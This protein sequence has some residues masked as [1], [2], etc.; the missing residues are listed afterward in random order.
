[1][2]DTI[3]SNTI[4]INKFVNVSINLYYVEGGQWGE[5]SMSLDRSFWVQYLRHDLSNDIIIDFNKISTLECKENEGKNVEMSRVVNTDTKDLKKEDK[6]T[7]NNVIKPKFVNDTPGKIVINGSD[8]QINWEWKM[9]AKDS[10]NN[11]NYV[12][13]KIYLHLFDHCTDT[14]LTSLHSEK[15]VPNNGTYA[16][17][18]DIPFISQRSS[19]RDVYLV[20]SVSIDEIPSNIKIRGK[21]MASKSLKYN[22]NNN[23]ES[24]FHR[25]DTKNMG[26]SIS[27][28]KKGCGVDTLSKQVIVAVSNSF[29][30][31]RLTTISEFEFLYATFCRTFGLEMEVVTYNDLSKYGFHVSKNNLRIC[32]NIRKSIPSEVNYGGTYCPGQYTI[33]SKALAVKI[34][35]NCDINKSNDKS[36][37]DMES[38][39]FLK[40]QRKYIDIIENCTLNYSTYWWLSSPDRFLLKNGIILDT[41]IFLPLTIKIMT[42]LKIDLLILYMRNLSITKMLN[43][44]KRRFSIF[45]RYKTASNNDFYLQ[46]DD[47]GGGYKKT[48]NISSGLLVHSNYST[49]YRRRPTWRSGK[50]NAWR[51]ILNFVSLK[52]HKNARNGSL[53]DIDN[54]GKYR[55][56]ANINDKTE[57]GRNNDNNRFANKMSKEMKTINKSKR[58][59]SNALMSLKLAQLKKSPSKLFSTGGRALKKGYIALGR[60]DNNDDLDEYKSGDDNIESMSKSF[61][62]ESSGKFSREELK[63]DNNDASL[64]SM[65]ESSCKYTELTNLNGVGH[66]RRRISSSSAVDYKRMKTRN[67]DDCMFYGY[68]IGYGGILVPLYIAKIKQRQEIIREIWYKL[69]FSTFPVV[70]KA[71]IYVFQLTLLSIFPIT[72]IILTLLYNYLSTQTISRPHTY[73]SENYLSDIVFNPRWSFFMSI[74]FPVPYLILISLL[75]LLIINITFISS[76]TSYSAKASVINNNVNGNN[77]RMNRFYYYWIRILIFFEDI[78]MFITLFSTFLTLLAISMFFLWFLLGSLINSDNI[79]PYVVMLLALGFVIVSL[80]NNFT[81]SR[82]IVDKFIAEN[83]QSLISIAL[84]HWFEATNQNYNIMNN[85]VVN[86]T[87]NSNY[88]PSFSD[89]NDLRSK[90]SEKLQYEILNNRYAWSKNILDEHKYAHNL[91]NSTNKRYMI[92]DYMDVMELKHS[93]KMSRMY[94]VKSSSFSIL[95]DYCDMYCLKWEYMKISPINT[96]R[97]F[98]LC[99]NGDIVG[100]NETISIYYGMK[101]ATKKDVLLN[102]SKING[103]LSDLDIV[104][105]KDGIKYG[106]KYGYKLKD[107]TDKD[108]NW[109]KFALVKIPIFPTS[110]I[111]SEEAKI[112]LIFDFFDVDQDGYLNKKETLQWIINLNYN[113]KYFVNGDNTKYTDIVEY[114]N[115][116]FNL[117]VDDRYGFVIDDIYTIYSFN[118]KNVNIDYEKIIPVFNYSCYENMDI[119]NVNNSLVGERDRSGSEFGFGVEFDQKKEQEGDNNENCGIKN[120]N[121]NNKLIFVENYIDEEEYDDEFE[122]NIFKLSG[123]EYNW[124]SSSNNGLGNSVGNNLEE[125]NSFVS[126]LDQK[127]YLWTDL[128]SNDNNNIMYKRESRCNNKTTEIKVI[129]TDLN[130]LKL[131]SLNK[132]KVNYDIV[133]NGNKGKARGRK[134]YNKFQLL[135]EINVQKLKYIFTFA[136]R[137][138]KTPDIETALKDIHSLAYKVF[139]A[140]IALLIPIFGVNNVLT[141][142]N[143]SLCLR[144]KSFSNWR[145][146]IDGDFKN[147]NKGNNNEKRA[148]ILSLG[149]KNSYQASS[150]L[151]SSFSSTSFVN[152]NG[153]GNTR[154]T[155]NDSN[156]LNMSMGSCNLNNVLTSGNKYQRKQSINRGGSF[157][158]MENNINSDSNGNVITNSNN[159]NSNIGYDDGLGE[160]EEDTV[161]FLQLMRILHN[162]IRQ[163]IWLLFNHIL[164]KLFNNNRVKN[165][166]NHFLDTIYPKLVRSKA[167]RIVNIFYGPS[168]NELSV[169]IHEYFASAPPKT[170]AQVMDALK[171][172]RVENQRNV[173]DTLE[174]ISLSQGNASIQFQVSLITKALYALS[175]LKDND[176]EMLTV[177]IPWK[178]H[179]TFITE[180][181]LILPKNHQGMKLILESIQIVLRRVNSITGTSSGG[182]SIGMLLGEN[183]TNANDGGNNNDGNKARKRHNNSDIDLLQ[184]SLIDSRY[185][186]EAHG[187]TITN[188]EFT[189]TTLEQIIQIIVSRYLWMDSFIFLIRLCGINLSTDR[190]PSVVYDN[191]ASITNLNYIEERNLEHVKNIFTK[192]S[193]GSG[194]LPVELSDLAIQTLTDKCLNFPGLLVSMN[195]LGLISNNMFL[196]CTGNPMDR[197]NELG[198]GNFNVVNVNHK[199]NINDLFSQNYRSRSRFEGIEVNK[200]DKYVLEN[201][202]FS[203]DNGLNVTM[204]GGIGNT[205]IGGNI[206]NNL[207]NNNN[208]N[209]NASNKMLIAEKTCNYGELLDWTLLSN[210]KGI[211]DDIVKDFRSIAILRCG[212]IGRSQLHDYITQHRKLYIN[213]DNIGSC[214]TDNIDS[215]DNSNG[216]TSKDTANNI[217]NKGGSFDSMENS[218]YFE[219][220]TMEDD[221]WLSNFNISFDIF[222]VALTTLGFSSHRLQSYILWLLLCL[223]IN[224]DSIQLFINARLARDFIT[225][226]YLKP[227]YKCNDNAGASS[228][229][230]THND[231]NVVNDGIGIS[232]VGISGNNNSNNSTINCGNN[233]DNNSASGLK[234]NSSHKSS[235]FDLS[236]QQ[237]KDLDAQDV[238]YYNGYFTYEMLRRFL[239]LAKITIPDKG[240]KSIWE[241]LP[242]D[243]LDV[244][245]FISPYK[246]ISFRNTDTVRN[247]INSDI[248]N[249]I[250]FKDVKLTKKKSFGERFKRKVTI[251]SNLDSGS[252]EDNNAY[253]SNYG[254]VNGEFSRSNSNCGCGGNLGIENATEKESF[255]LRILMDQTGMDPMEG[256]IVSITTVKRLVPKKL[257]TGL[258]PEAIKVLLNIGLHLEKSDLSI[259]EA[260]SRCLEYSNKYG[261]IRPGDIVSILAALNKE[262]LS[263]DLLCELLNNMRIQ[264]PVRDVKRMFDLMDLNQDKS[265]DL[266]E[267]LDG[268]EVLFGLFLPKLVHVH[269]GLSYERQSIIII[270]TSTALLL[271]CAFVGIAIK[272]F[273]G[274]RNELSTAVQSVL[275]I[276]GA[277]G[278]QTGASKDS[279]EIEERMKER[280]EDIMG[281]DIDTSTSQI[282]YSNNGNGLSSGELLYGNVNSNTALNGN[283]NKI[284]IKNNNATSNGDLTTNSDNGNFI[285]TEK[286]T[287]L[288]ISYNYSYNMFPCIPNDPKPCITFYCNDYVHLEPVFYCTKGIVNQQN[289]SFFFENV[290]IVWSIKPNLPKYTGLTFNTKNGI[291]KGTIPLYFNNKKRQYIKRNTISDL[292]KYIRV[293]NN[294][295]GNNNFINTNSSTIN[296]NNSSKLLRKISN[297]NISNN[298]KSSKATIFKK[299][300]STNNHNN[301]VGEDEGDLYYTDDIEGN[302]RNKRKEKGIETGGRCHHIDN[303]SDNE[304][305]EFNSNNH[306]H[307][308]HS[309]KES[310]EYLF[311]FNNGTD[312]ENNDNTNTLLAHN[313]QF[314]QMNKQ[315]FNVY[316]T[317]NELNEKI[318]YKTRITFQILPGNRK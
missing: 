180:E 117:N 216:N 25:A 145:K 194:F 91:N 32:E 218:K 305:S 47:F 297:I 128:L 103:L 270:A 184:S 295:K 52:G 202:L 223:N 120:K 315:I 261:L 30:V 134:K 22:S 27:G 277:V 34:G 136:T 17:S 44:F 177:D 50:L 26:G 8:T 214:G 127:G 55:Y 135:R 49:V 81:S 229:N 249:N 167:A 102:N 152:W 33:S 256:V 98:K 222:D 13:K 199:V 271:F 15:T 1:V 280:I 266:Q 288:K 188:N 312:Y 114:I 165:G 146:E 45:D 75:H 37:T 93:T 221:N 24:N 150:Q 281:G 260:T 251:T 90:I 252:Y 64:G 19:S 259:M 243:P 248:N 119:K 99:K 175:L 190:L 212:F 156:N 182:G 144:D 4:S 87:T 155:F 181:V 12:P 142:G 51:I 161:K 48:I 308:D 198:F 139:D 104:L 224:L 286:G 307:F 86:N 54:D 112:K 158:N 238:E 116:I 287:I 289:N 18:V 92:Q 274:M 192:L 101:L 193:N 73:I 56:I 205:V 309:Y 263:F 200:D 147:G 236:Y 235:M 172:Y 215:N 89:P 206:N 187:S 82:G 31:I 121:S 246:N 232:S 171:E 306:I 63:E 5:L 110:N 228:G 285:L 254:N 35:N 316:C 245:N 151:L 174:I 118:P 96:K 226:L 153:A 71:I 231:N 41:S 317:V 290:N 59:W 301:S 6:E 36:D 154:G 227:K 302:T 314:V 132:I 219:K 197:L 133:S 269:V 292:N 240:V 179:H 237:Y 77:G 234:L 143:V 20:M 129:T 258:W 11:I 170:A 69:Q 60:G 284:V 168:L 14:F 255:Y 230:N 78:G 204:N 318:V 273:E 68:N 233:N 38:Y 111:L 97:L 272:T 124:V 95:N 213:E 211:P 61:E 186:E 131:V 275:A 225:M 298:T 84:G 79:L 265:L 23:G 300:S 140:Q 178:K 42:L 166:A 57:I 267:L 239:V 310:D 148:S 7:E 209:Y 304:S 125:N 189:E 169:S 313:N 138:L 9:N 159:N 3:S 162:E 303:N 241:S 115:S 113:E 276:V 173:K 21:M 185:I 294:S 163:D 164:G 65:R 67:D 210:V 311:D 40:S 207:N 39:M 100:I 191:S 88:C 201:L 66:D 108:N 268:F 242:K 291:I 122:D 28:N 196:L 160:T 247:N 2:H 80:W 130:N 293:I 16:W 278:L 220:M 282:E 296:V 53:N 137:N 43:R 29:K 183:N 109:Y 203:G 244:T 283:N 76:N 46:E 58:R 279:S 157:P 126:L 107:F 10:N 253:E 176:V 123:S 106:S 94:G 74:S 299:F 262:G 105:L 250:D 70:F 257:M 195:F 141:S 217:K 83:L 72:C 208:V 264:L 62:L 149:N 85:S